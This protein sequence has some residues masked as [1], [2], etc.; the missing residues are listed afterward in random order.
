MVDA[1]KAKN[2]EAI[3]ALELFVQDMG[4]FIRAYDF[5]SQIIDSGDTDLEKHYIF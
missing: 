4:S 1:K 3:D 2:E 5:L